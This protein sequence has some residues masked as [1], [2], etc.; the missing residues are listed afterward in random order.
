M[1][2]ISRSDVGAAR[3]AILNWLCVPNW[4]GVY[5]LGC[6][7]RH[8]TVRS[9][10][11]RALN[12]VYSLHEEF[13]LEGKSVAIIGAGAAGLTAAAAALMTGRGLRYSK[14]GIAN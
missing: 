11:V 9:Q 14:K 7:A 10:Q 13:G 1:N 5:V 3:V 2:P 8:V 12:L 4:T 6:F